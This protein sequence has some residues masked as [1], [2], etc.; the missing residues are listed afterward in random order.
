MTVQGPKRTIVLKGIG[1]SPGIADGRAHLL[2]NHR[3][4]PVAHHVITDPALVQLEVDRF[5]QALKDSEQELAAIREKLETA[6]GMGPLILEVHIM[7]LKDDGLREQ[8][9]GFIKNNGINAEWA[10]EMTLARYRGIFSRMEDD[11][12][13]ARIRDIEDVVHR[14]L[15]HLSG[16]RQESIDDI[17]E[18]TVIVA[19][20]LS[21]AET[22]QMKVRKILGFA[23]DVGGKTSHTTIVARSIGIPAV[24]G[25]EHITRE[26]RNGDILVV[27]GT[28][29]VVIVS[30]DQ[31]TLRRY[32][33][34][35]LHYYLLGE[36]YLKDAR[37][38]AL[39]RDNH[40]VG[41]G[42]NLEF[43]EEIP[44]AVHHGAN[45]VGLYRTEFFYVNREQPPT[46]E[47]HFHHYRTIIENED[48]KWATIRTFDLGGDKFISDPRLA[49]EMNPAMGLRA[50]RY[51]LQEPEF[52]EVQLR[53]ILRASA[54]GNTGIMIPMI[55]G[56]EEIRAVKTIIARVKEELRAG[57]VPFN[58]G[59]KLGIMIEVPSAVMMAD[60]LAR[61]VDFFSIGT[62]DLIQYSLAIDRV[63]EHVGH[64]YRP[65]HPAVLRLIR[66]VVS[67]GHRA[68][69]KVAMC[70]EMAGDPFCTMLLLGLELDGLSMTPLAIPRVK[71]IIREV[72]FKESRELLHRVL[73][74]DQT[75]EIEEYVKEYMLRKFP[76]YCVDDQG[77]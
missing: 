19:H 52:F 26:V 61:E 30:P 46:E 58:E 17:D 42:A 24:V 7:M 49:D 16:I 39:T 65:C 25:L 75:D 44:S 71:A 64:L 37:L 48:L 10:L 57:G 74:F 41:V 63:N 23:T 43:I 68:G 66:H 38:P 9:L 67:A 77:D 40:S 12:L 62:N 29:G 76:E 8:T 59:I 1:V 18:G 56:V 15:R 35:K 3:T 54:Y 45:G 22:V 6:E 60:A 5:R 53:G 33:D 27:D 72:T 51:C 34:K 32:E 70:G 20:D 4:M 14:I 28:S 73:A 50:V 36:S 11:Y 13:K 55:S 69:I 21:P 31:E 47:E 2:D